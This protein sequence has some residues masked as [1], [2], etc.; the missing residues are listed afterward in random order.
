VTASWHLP[1]PVS[2][3]VVIADG[4]GFDILGGLAT[5]DVSTDRLVQVDP[6]HGSAHVA[7]VLALAV[8]DSAGAALAGRDYVFGGGSYQ[9]VSTVQSWAGGGTASEVGHLPRPRSDLAAVT[10]GATAYIVGGFDGSNLDADVLSTTDGT[11]FRAVASLPVPVRYPAVAYAA[12]MIWVLG[13]VTTTNESGTL[14]TSAIQKVDLTTGRAAVVGHLPQPLGHAAA[15][16]LAGQVYL[17][18]GRSGSVP[19]AAIWRLDAAT[20]AVRPA[21][22]LPQ[23][24]SDA[25]AVVVD[26]TAY[27]V[28]G[29]IAGPVAPLDTV[30]V[31][32]PAPP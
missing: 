21:G 5:G 2:R 1:D 31:L 19:S 28:G 30:V 24:R 15:V 20:G 29:E 4:S 17:L 8:H 11:T 32:R 6:A 10:N 25:G 16:V 12:G 22:T 7:G 9:T 23:A 14:E 27:L 3:P 26:G 18:G 13:G